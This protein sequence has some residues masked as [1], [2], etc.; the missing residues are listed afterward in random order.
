MGEVIE[1][2]NCVTFHKRDGILRPL[3]LLFR[4]LFKDIKRALFDTIILISNNNAFVSTFNMMCQYR[5]NI[6][7]L[8]SHETFF[9]QFFFR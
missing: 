4:K 7:Y 3:I 6:I 2:Y 8:N 5:Y 9:L 1:N